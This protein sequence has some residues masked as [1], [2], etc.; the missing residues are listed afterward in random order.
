MSRSGDRLFFILVLTLA[1]GGLAIFSSAA[2][3]L[4]ARQSSTITRD[5]IDQVVFGLGAGI[6]ALLVLRSLSLAFIKKCAPYVYGFTLLLTALV[7]V[8][9]IGVHSLGATRWINVGFTTLQPAE[10]LKI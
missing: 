2:L 6:I 9:G 10:F 3:G 8:P 1:L 4:L 5:I 7:F